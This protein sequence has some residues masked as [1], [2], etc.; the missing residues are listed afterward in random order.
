MKKINLLL[1]IYILLTIL[2]VSCDKP[3]TIVCQNGG[4]V[5]EDCGCNCPLGYTGS[6]CQIVLPLKSVTVTSIIVYNFPTSTSGLYWD[7]GTTSGKYP[8]M[9]ININAGT[10]AAAVQTSAVHNNITSV[11]QTYALNPVTLYNPQNNYTI[12]LYDYD[13]SDPDDFMGGIYFKPIN[14]RAGYPSTIHLSNSSINID[15]TIYVTWN[16]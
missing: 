11:P 8:D 13:P 10:T 16:F 9:Y 7:P 5:T 3:C 12:S 2:I 6:N 14:Y 4:F 1:P 15:Y